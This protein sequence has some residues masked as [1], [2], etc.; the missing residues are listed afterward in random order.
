[1]LSDEAT[2]IRWLLEAGRVLAFCGAGVS[3]ESGLP[4]FRG[5]GGLWEGR[6]VEDVATPEAFWRNPKTVWR[7]YAERQEALRRVEPNPAHQVLAAMEARD[8]EFLLVTQNVDDLHERAGSRKL[9]KLH[10]SL[11]E[12]RC[13]RCRAVTPLEQ[14]VSVSQVAAGVLPHCPCGDLLRPNVVWFGEPL[15]RRH[16]EQIQAFFQQ[17]PLPVGSAGPAVLLVIGTSG[18]VSAGYGITTL[19]R[20]YGARIVEI[21]PAA[22]AFSL[23]ADLALRAPAGELLERVWGEL[24]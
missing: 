20:R 2:L 7:F 4:T 6:R 1:M 22:S 11:M 14:P 19:A 5:A 17:C 3:A 18:T 12:V 23:D 21:N 16:F 15:K 8:R 13:T 24:S 10:G 9:I